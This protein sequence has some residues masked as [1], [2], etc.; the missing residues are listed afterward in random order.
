MKREEQLFN[1]YKT[2]END[3][4]DLIAYKVYGDEFKMNHLQKA[5]VDFIKVVVFSPGVL[6][7]IPKIEAMI[8]EELPPWATE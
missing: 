7:K 5:N 8:I 4:W 1:V 6:L 2:Q 3:T